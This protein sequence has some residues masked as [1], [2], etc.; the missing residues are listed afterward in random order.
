LK[1]KK[2]SQ[3]EKKKS[4]SERSRNWYEKNKIKAVENAR[5]WK[6][7]NPEKV[8]LS[9]SKSRQNPESKSI[10]FMRDSLRRVLKIEKKGRTEKL[11]GY[12]RHELMN[13]IEKQFTKKMSWAN[14]GKYWEI[15]HITPVSVLIKSGIADPS[16]I[17]CLSNLRPLCKIKN[18]AK[19]AKVEV[20]L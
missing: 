9:E 3:D 1:I 7:E 20:L 14:Y 6:K 13:H 12:T 15:D 4:Q 11:L 2:K 5:H 16:F 8:R 10:R 18:R 19:S 17:N